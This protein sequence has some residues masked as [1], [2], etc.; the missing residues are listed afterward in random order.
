MT[1][2]DAIP[3]EVEIPIE[4]H[5][6]LHPFAPRDVV[7]VVASYLEAAIERGF[8]QVR[9]IHGKGIGVQRAAV[10]R[11]LDRHPGVAGY[12]D[13]D[14]LRGGWGATIVTLRSNR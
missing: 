4:D 6:D 11:L 10:R 9:L 1:E 13:D 8:T 3:D 12:R 2:D 5:L 14:A 7:D